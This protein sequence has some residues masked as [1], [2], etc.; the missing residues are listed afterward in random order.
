M[1]FMYCDAPSTIA[2][3]RPAADETHAGAGRVTLASGATF[4]I[5]VAHPA[6][7]SPESD[8][9]VK[10]RK[11]DKIQLCY[12]PPQKWADAGPTARM[13]IVGDL[14]NGAYFYGLA[15]P[16]KGTAASQ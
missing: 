8:F 1:P 7:P 14:N 6:N 15:Y 4:E 12:A 3:I 2:Q 16:A 13:A 9:V 10:L 11:T 5:T